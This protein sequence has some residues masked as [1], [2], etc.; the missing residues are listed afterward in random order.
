M[1]PRAPGKATAGRAGGKS[2]KKPEAPTKPLLPSIDDAD[3]TADLMPPAAFRE[4]VL[5]EG[6]IEVVGGDNTTPWKEGPAR[7]SLCPRP[8][9]KH[10]AS[11]DI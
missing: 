7:V 10:R 6:L 8:T 11:S 5:K 1:P 9:T 3:I 4:A 2:T